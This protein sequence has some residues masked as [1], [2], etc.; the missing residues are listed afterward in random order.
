MSVS[1]AGE[2]E[3]LEFA[4]DGTPLLWTSSGFDDRE[5]YNWAGNQG[6]LPGNH[7]FTVRSRTPSTNPSIPRMICSINLHEFG[8]E[9]EYHVDN[10]FVSAYPTW[11]DQK[12]IT[13]RPTNA[14]CLMRNITH[15]EFCSVCKEE[16]WIQFLSK[17][18]LIDSLHVEESP[19]PDGSFGIVLTTLKLGQ[20]RAPG[21]EVEGESWVV[22]WFLG[23]VLQEEWNN[24]FAINATTGVWDV[25]VEFVTDEVKLDSERLLHDERRFQV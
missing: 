9:S 6:F 8:N 23:N 18:S 13:Y 3:S 25:R 16:M 19:N 21:N 24:L 14:G 22:Q 7:I 2:S 11:D 17:I 15:N 12:R 5:F 1:A 10:S 4:I 20:F